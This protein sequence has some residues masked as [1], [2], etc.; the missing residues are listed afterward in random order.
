MGDWES[1][2]TFNSRIQIFKQFSVLIFQLFILLGSEAEVVIA[3][4]FLVS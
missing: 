3:I 1:G 4:P 2:I